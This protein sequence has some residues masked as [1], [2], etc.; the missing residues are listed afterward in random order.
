M[1]GGK[2]STLYRLVYV[3]LVSLP[4]VIFYILKSRYVIANID[5]YTEQERYSLV[6]RMIYIMEKNGRV[7]TQIYGTENLPQ[8]GGYVMYSN[9]QGKYDALGIIHA[10]KT[11]C[12]FLI[13]EKRA[14]IPF[15]W[16][17]TRLLKASKLD[18]TN[19]RSELKTIFQIAKQV[20]DGRR[21]IIFPEGGYEDNSNDLDVFKPG[22][23]KC[24]VKSKTPIVP[25]VL[26]D[27]YKVFG[28]NSLK[29][30]RPQVHFLEPIYYE[31][32]SSMTTVEIAKVVQKRIED[33]ILS[34]T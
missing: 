25:V 1:T 26:I 14:K 34:N 3:I 33:T 20:E 24:S 29:K 15:A 18:K 31:E 30:V 11:P 13:D 6:Q 32:Y 9:H 17:I 27:S 5:N 2:Y 22:A 19:I 7:E 16:E 12:T 23:F 10:H 8:K 28:V 4:I 21:Y